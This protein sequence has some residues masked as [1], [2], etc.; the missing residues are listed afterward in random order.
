V[1]SF[2]FRPLYSQGPNTRT[3]QLNAAVTLRKT[4][5][6]SVLHVV[7]GAQINIQ[8]GC[9]SSAQRAWALISWRTGWGN[10]VVLDRSST[11]HF[12]LKSSKWSW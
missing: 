6:Q 11:I 5:R 12:I 2:K 3:P 8:S 4:R 1:V 7:K 9:R 10:D